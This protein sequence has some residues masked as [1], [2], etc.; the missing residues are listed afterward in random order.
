MLRLA[1][2]VFAL[3]IA[4]V[5]VTALVGYLLPAAHIAER[6]QEIAAPPDRVFAAITDVETFPSWRSGVRSVEVL[7]R[8]PALRWRERGTHDAILFEQVEAVR[9]ARLVTRIADP[10]LPFGGTWTCTVEPTTAG[11]RVTIRED[12]VVH[13]PIFRVMSRFV[14]GHTATIDAYLKDLDGYLRR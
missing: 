3:L 9:P 6:Q 11:S 13:N 14:F 5:V 2:L 12:G 7:A 1:L 10:S 4:L 8:E